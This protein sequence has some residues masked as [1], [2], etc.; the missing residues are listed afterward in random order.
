MDETCFAKFSL[1]SKI[2]P[3]TRTESTDSIDSPMSGSEEQNHTIFDFLVFKIMSL[4]SHQFWKSDTTALTV[5]LRSSRF[6]AAI[7][8]PRSSAKKY[9][10][11]LAS[12]EEGFCG[13]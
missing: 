2:T 12:G 6:V 5:I 13:D 4:L 9:A 1:R 8:N 7:F 3:K 10:D 11:T